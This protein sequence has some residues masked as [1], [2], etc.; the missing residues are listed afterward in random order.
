[1]DKI[2][3]IFSN[4]EKVLRWVYPGILFIVLL[5]AVRPEWV[6]R[7]VDIVGRWGVFF[8]TL[9]V[10]FALFLVYQLVMVQTYHLIM[11]GFNWDVSA[12]DGQDER[13]KP[14]TR[15]WRMLAKYFF[16]RDA[17]KIERRMNEEKKTQGT[18]R[19][20]PYTYAD[21]LWSICHAIGITGWL[22]VTFFWFAGLPWG[23]LGGIAIFFSFIMYLRLMRVWDEAVNE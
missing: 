12:Q 16:D 20:K 15:F 7:A 14:K 3:T 4:F 17:R 5:Y 18:L 13:P 21:Y 23:F 10:G 2:D 6:E 9:G 19:K 1:M 22:L 11:I 8:G